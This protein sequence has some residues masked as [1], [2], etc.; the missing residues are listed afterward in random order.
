MKVLVTGG[1]GYVGSAVV[2]ELLAAGASPV[3]FDNLSEGHRKAVPEGTPLVV[4]DID[5]RP[6]MEETL[7]HHGIEAVIHMAASCLVGQSMERP[8]VYYRNNVTAGVALL[9]A[10]RSAEVDR[11]V[12]SSSAAT[13]GEPDGTPIREE[14]RTE[15]CSPYG[16]TKLIFERVLHWYGSAFGMHHVA[17]RYFNAAG[18]NEEIGE[19]HEP[20]T[21]LIP[22]VLRVALG[23]TEKVK[24]FGDDYPTVDGSCERDFVHVMDLARAHVLALERMETGSGVY[25]LGG[26]EGHTV[27]EVIATCREATGHPIPAVVARRRP[28]DPARL[29][30]SAAK[31]R[32]QLD[33]Q[34]QR[35]SLR[36]I[37]ESA[38]N[39]HERNPNGYED[40]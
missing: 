16:E 5:D 9:D 38:W 12:F 39:W 28:G 2:A 3:V 27:K 24:I 33:W 26:G 18:A 22:L 11:I 8:D 19:D 30:A 40:A 15:P 1:A 25:N 36:D 32:T 23:K 29:V 37:V 20:E 34:P 21:H 14:D 13:Y 6:V 10:M 4:G 17:L 35:S 31:A 7:L